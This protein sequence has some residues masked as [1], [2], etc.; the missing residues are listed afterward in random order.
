MEF[1]PVGQYTV[2]ITAPGFSKFEQAGIVIAAIQSTR[3]DATLYPGGLTESLEVR[4]GAPLVNTN[5][6]EVATTVES[7]LISELP[8]VNRNVYTLLDIT[9]GVQQNSNQVGLGLPEQHTSMNGGGSRILSF[10]QGRA[11]N[12]VRPR[13][14]NRRSD[15]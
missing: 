2:E 10:G 15:G 1:L 7:T 14:S 8:I 13:P 4:G 5:N 11:S 9:P 12:N 3:V 6:A